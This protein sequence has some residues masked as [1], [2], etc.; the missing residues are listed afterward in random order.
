MSGPRRSAT[1]ASLQKQRR[2][3]NK[4]NPARLHVWRGFCV[5]RSSDAHSAPADLP[6]RAEMG[7]KRSFAPV[8][9]NGGNAPIAV[10]REAPSILVAHR[11]AVQPEKI[12]ARRWSSGEPF[13]LGWAFSTPPVGLSHLFWKS[14]NLSRRL[15]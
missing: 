2:R 5:L 10:I 12:R 11:G 14:G 7:G 1:G 6:E 13:G 8:P 9:V 3:R 15:V 4:F